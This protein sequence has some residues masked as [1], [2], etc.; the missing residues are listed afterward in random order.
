MYK[1][2]ILPLAEQDIR[3]AAQWYEKRQPGLGRRFTENVRNKVDYTCRQPKAV[4]VHYDDIR[5]IVLD[6]VPYMI[7]FWVEED[8]QRIIVTAVLH[9]SR[10][11]RLWKER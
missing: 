7:H 2:V 3:E 11:P 6:R 9:T 10:S 8:K 1:A 4:A 5:T